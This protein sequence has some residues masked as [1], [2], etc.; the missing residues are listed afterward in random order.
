MPCLKL[1]LP[2]VCFLGMLAG[3]GSRGIQTP[4]TAPVRGA[5]TR[6]GQP[7]P[8][9]RVKFHPQ[10][11]IGPVKFTPTGETDPHGRFLLSTGAAD[12]GAP[13]GEYLVTL[14]KFRIESDREHGGIEVEVD[15]LKGAYAE[16]A[17]S[18]WRVS[19]QEGDNALEPFTLD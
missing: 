11:D 14:E 16:P 19:I 2:L 4:T 3:C 17:S 10:F 6:R 13:P 9:V 8:G 12:N 15:E 5:V 7:V 18:R 1:Q